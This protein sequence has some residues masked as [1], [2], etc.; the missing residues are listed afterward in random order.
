MKDNS[1]YNEDIGPPGK[2][3][4]PAI[5]WVDLFKEEYLG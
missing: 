3:V 5:E 1:I 2:A 4:K